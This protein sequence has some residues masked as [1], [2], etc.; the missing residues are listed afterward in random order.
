MSDKKDTS[1]DPDKKRPFIR[2]KIAKPPMTKRQ[3]LRR[4][5]AC[6][7][8]AVLAG[9]AAGASFAVA[10]PLADKYLTPE[11]TEE[12]IAVTIPTDVEPTT[13]AAA[14]EPSESSA[15]EETEPIEEIMQSAIEQYQYNIH[16]FDMMYDALREV[17]QTAD[18]SIVVIHSVQQ[19]VDWFDNPL[20]T[21]G[22]YAG[23]V[24]AS[25][26]REYLILAPDTAVETADAISVTFSNNAEAAGTVRQTDSVS[27]MTVISVNKSD[28]AEESQQQIQAVLLGNSYNLRQGDVMIAVG[29][30]SGAVHS[31]AYGF[32]SYVQRNV[33]VADG[34]TRLLYADIRGNAGAGTFLVNTAGEL[35]GWATGEFQDEENSGMTAIMAISEYKMILEKLMNGIPVPYLGVHGQEV[36][37]A[38]R[39]RGVPI[40]VYVSECVADSPMYYAGILSGDVITHVGGR[41]IITMMDYENKV[42]ELVTGDQ[43]TVKVQ[44]QGAEE[45]IEL[46]YH[47]TVGAR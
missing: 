17:V 30:P 29:A 28:L 43:V 16:D 2:E 18:S 42:S 41:D 14:E 47:V 39:E 20:E 10:G 27:G 44:R 11:T 21:S 23:I 37:Q 25:T 6:V 1:R 32:L 5:L 15:E 13:S 3:A 31:S 45:Y 33:Q 38:M 46:E 8:I 19:G 7:F 36:T 24:I 35:I 40:G 26:D 12:A 9:A 22:A 4:F 34:T